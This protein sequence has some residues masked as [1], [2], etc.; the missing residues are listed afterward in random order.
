MGR[1][2]RR[3]LLGVAAAVT[4]VIAVPARSAPVAAG[5]P[6]ASATSP[7]PA[8]P[9]APP[10]PGTPLPAGWEQCILQGVGAPVTP[11]NVANLDEWQTAEG[12][13]TN[14]AAAFNPFNSRRATDADNAPLP[15]S[16]TPGG[17]PAF[18]TWEAGCAATVAT[19]LQPTMAPVVTALQVGTVSPP[20]IFLAAVDQSPWCAPSP[21]G[22]PCYASDI[23]A[24]ELLSALLSGRS[25]GLSTVLTSYADTGTDLVTYE[26]AAYVSVV[27]DGLLA[28]K[29]AALQAAE[30]AYGGAQA[31]YA[32][33]RDA[34]RRLALENY[35]SGADT[36]FDQS[37]SLVTTPDEQDDI[38]QYFQGVATTLLISRFEGAKAARDGAHA[39]EQVAQADVTQATATANAASA[40]ETQAL[41]GLEGDVQGLEGSMSCT[42]APIVPTSAAPV[43]TVSDAGQLWQGLEACLAPAAP[44]GAG[45]VLETAP[46]GS[47]ASARS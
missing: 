22:V 3:A 45:G 7:T 19:L 44:P 35:T 39:K 20:G 8:R 14:N 28:V 4:F 5:A 40:T 41:S 16:G 47:V 10:V 31:T 32:A 37:L 29:S 27:E 1:P 30:H 21:D 9:A 24:S 42:P 6:S 34:L 12:G 23:L 2:L 25:K 17:F 38:A 46:A 33:T 15:V 43:E 18:T 13:S 26:K 36:R 11:Q